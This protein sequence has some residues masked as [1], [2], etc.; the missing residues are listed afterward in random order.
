MSAALTSPPALFARLLS[1]QRERDA[2]VKLA[3]EVDANGLGASQRDVLAVLTR[4][5]ATRLALGKAVDATPGVVSTSI[6]GL[7]KRGYIE[8]VDDGVSTV[9]RLTLLGQSVAGVRA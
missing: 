9:W 3:V 7:R 4:G 8:C 6:A 1:A 2:R 5:P